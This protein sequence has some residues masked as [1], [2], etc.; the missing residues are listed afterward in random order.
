MNAYN[1]NLRQLFQALLDISPDNEGKPDH[2]ENLTDSL[3]IVATKHGIKPAHLNGQGLRSERIL[4]ALE[5]IALQYGLLTLRTNSI[6]PYEIRR[7]EYEREI[8]DW[9][10]QEDASKRRAT[11]DILWIYKDPALKDFIHETVDGQIDVSQ[12][13]GYPKC[14]VEYECQSMVQLT[15]LYVNGL[16]KTYG[17]SAVSDVIGLIEKDATTSIEGINPMEEMRQSRL[18][19]PYVQFTACPKCLGG[20]NSSA[21]QINAK[22]RDIAFELSDSFGL[23]IWRTNLQSVW[24]DRLKNLG[25]NDL[26]PCGGGKKYKKCC[27][28]LIGRT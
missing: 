9:Q 3:E 14:C 20:T 17:V 25:R 4:R 28:A 11:P 22:M 13:L 12:V 5:C 19:F 2:A 1:Q 6:N 21:A 24:P 15:E 10:K 23:D 26:C 18:L 7:P 8:Y 27:Q 16:K